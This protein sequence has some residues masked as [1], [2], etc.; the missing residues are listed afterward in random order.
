MKLLHRDDLFS[1]SEFNEER[2]LDF[3]SWLWQRR[4]GNL[5]IDPLPMSTH[6]QQRLESLGGAKFIV[7]TNSDHCRDAEKIARDT[8][9]K[10]YGP[11]Q[12][13][14]NFPL[15]CNHW[16]QNGD[17]VVPGLIVIELAGSKTPGELAL[18]LE[19]NTLI[20]G[21]LIRC[22]KAGELCL[23]PDAKLSDKKMAVES[24]RHLAALP[25][26]DAVLPGDG[27]PIFRY[28][29]EAIIRLVRTLSTSS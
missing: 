21:D 12:E 23:L 8:G 7:I 3:N 14:T 1:W 15:A 27:W 20:T 25:G 29:A 10:L 26:V 24:L 5:L 6:D 28:G 11:N 9:A 13:K 4:D 16:L 2:E 19:D 18:L 17:Q 22:H